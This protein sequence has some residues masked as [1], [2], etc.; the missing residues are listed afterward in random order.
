[1][2]EIAYDMCILSEDEFC[3]QWFTKGLSFGE[4]TISQQNTIRIPIPVP[5]AMVY[6]RFVVLY[7]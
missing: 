7:L 5:F 3:L 2:A 6:K 4:K 1:M